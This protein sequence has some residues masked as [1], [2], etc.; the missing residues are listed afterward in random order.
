MQDSFSEFS[1][2]SLEEKKV[3]VVAEIVQNL[4]K[5]HKDKQT[6]NLNSLKTKIASK[7]GMATS[8]RLVDIIAAVP[9]DY[10]K[11]LV[12]KLLAKP[13]RTASGVSSYKFK[14]ISLHKYYIY[15]IDCSSCCYV[16]TTPM[17]TY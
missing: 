3:I 17:S 11:I 16:Q 4:I 12:P 15:S 13:I 14:S 2:L 5:A 10:K 6:V 1:Y 8:P 7:Y 9:M